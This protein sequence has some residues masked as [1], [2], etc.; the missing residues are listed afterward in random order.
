MIYHFFILLW[1]LSPPSG[2]KKTDARCLYFAGTWESRSA[3]GS[4][5]KCTS[6]LPPIR[7]GPKGPAG[8]RTLCN[9][10]ATTAAFCPNGG[11]GR[12]HKAAHSVHSP[13][14]DCCVFWIASAALSMLEFMCECCGGFPPVWFLQILGSSVSLLNTLQITGLIYLFFFMK[15]IMWKWYV[16]LG[17]HYSLLNIVF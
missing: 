11:G 3:D 1:C 9:P 8:G 7:G 17:K 4:S 6:Q 15:E 10:A 5:S 16:I 12:R 2:Y 13:G 14:N